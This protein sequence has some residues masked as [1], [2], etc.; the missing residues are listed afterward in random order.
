MLKHVFSG[1]NRKIAGK[2]IYFAI[3]TNALDFRV[4]SQY[5]VSNKYLPH[6]KDDVPYM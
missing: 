6:A 4:I 5:H 3:I 2:Q 1:V